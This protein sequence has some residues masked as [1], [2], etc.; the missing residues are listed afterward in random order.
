MIGDLD[1]NEKSI[2]SVSGSVKSEGR[3]GGDA[4]IRKPEFR[5]LQQR[6][7]GRVQMRL[8]VRQTWNGETS[9]LQKRDGR[10]QVSLEVE[11]AWDSSIK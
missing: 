8:E 3:G 7:Q 9:H 6:L 2:Q 10:N 1:G 5:I 4:A 11:I